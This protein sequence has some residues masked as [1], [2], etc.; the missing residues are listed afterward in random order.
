MLYISQAPALNFEL[1]SK[2]PTLS[3]VQSSLSTIDK[4]KLSNRVFEISMFY[5]YLILYKIYLPHDPDLALQPI[6]N[7]L[8]DYFQYKTKSRKKKGF[9]FEELTP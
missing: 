8:I 3:I 2:Q 6:K 5:T 1:I 4:Q 9:F 7:I